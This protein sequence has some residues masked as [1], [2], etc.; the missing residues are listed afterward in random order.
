MFSKESVES[1]KPQLAR[2]AKMGIHIIGATTY[3]EY[4]EHIQ[5]N[6]ALT[7]RFPRINIPSP[8]DETVY[9]ILK[10]KM[11]KQNTVVESDASN[12]ILRKI[13]HNSNIHMQNKKSTS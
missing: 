5:P 11:R 8:N 2:S 13:I 10:N 4:I 9:Q 3:D 12:A 7:D 6:K 1:L